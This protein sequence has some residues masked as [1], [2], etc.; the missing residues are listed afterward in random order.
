LCDWIDSFAD[1][2]GRVKRLSAAATPFPSADFS[3]P[4]KP[5]DADTPLVLS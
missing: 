4:A 1:R 5:D 3:L 2:Q